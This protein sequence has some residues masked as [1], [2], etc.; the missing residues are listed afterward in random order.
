[1]TAAVRLHIRTERSRLTR[2]RL[3]EKH[4]DF[5]RSCGKSID[6]RG[7]RGNPACGRCRRGPGR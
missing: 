3:G 1:M 2:L 7:I 5:C 6:H 4:V